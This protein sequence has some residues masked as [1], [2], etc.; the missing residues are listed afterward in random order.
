MYDGKPCSG[1]A[2]VKCIRCA[3][4]HYGAAKGT[5]VALGQFAFSRLEA[6]R[7]DLFLPVSEATACGNNLPRLGLAH[8]VVPNFVAPEPDPAGHAPLLEALPTQ[9]FFL[10]V[11]D[12]RSDKG[13]H[14]L[15]DAYR[16]LHEPPPLILIGELW[17][18]TPHDLPPGVKLLRAWPNPAVRAAMKRSL[19]VVV[20]SLWP[21]PFGIVV[22]EAL[23]AGR[24]VVGSAIGGI[25]ELV[26]D[27]RE[28]LLVPPGDV[29]AL[30][31]ALERIC[32]D[33]ELREELA[34]SALRRARRYTPEAVVPRFEAAYERVASLRA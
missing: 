1:P 22:A 7:V 11:G 2:L 14:T 28:G 10:F 4:R 27:R 30:T 15:L 21:E 18:D 32:K 13:A 5:G 17:P 3:G 24:P 25:P 29:A 9:P 6:A 19:A 34:A 33:G 26:R 23:A 20:P 31:R 12:V 8:E 16:G